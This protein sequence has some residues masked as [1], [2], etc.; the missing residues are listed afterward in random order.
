MK[1]Y[2]RE[3]ATCDAYM[4]AHMMTHNETAWLLPRTEKAKEAVYVSRSGV[5]TSWDLSGFKEINNE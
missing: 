3:A 2:V 5:N 4:I 1:V